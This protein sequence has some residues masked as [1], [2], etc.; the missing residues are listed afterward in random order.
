MTLLKKFYILTTLFLLI[1]HNITFS[2]TKSF[3]PDAPIR[4]FRLPMFNQEGYQDWH[5]QGDQGIYITQEKVKIIGMEL[6]IF[7]GDHKN[8]L[9]ATIESPKA[10]IFPLENKAKSDNEIKVTGNTY[11]L[12]GKN[13]SWNGKF[14]KII[15]NQ[16][17][18]VIFTQSLENLFTYENK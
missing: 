13:W 5:I 2:E 17:V 15:I 12:S 1:I 11:N 8:L 7:S 4:N 3:I 16:N 6:N 14:K 10:T 18:K 9:E